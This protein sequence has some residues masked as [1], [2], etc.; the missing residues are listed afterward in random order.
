MR[1]R[2]A[3]TRGDSGDAGDSGG[4][5]RS[6]RGSGSSLGVAIIGGL[7]AV[8]LMLVPAGQV[9]TARQSAAGAADASALAAADVAVGKLP[10]SPCEEAQIVASA[11]GATLGECIVDGAV[12]TVQVS[13]LAGAF[14]VSARATAGPPGSPGR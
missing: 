13:T 2:G 7:I 1:L 10:G 6:Q 5:G 4:V 9:L 3:R 8:V 11:N 14:T 12:V